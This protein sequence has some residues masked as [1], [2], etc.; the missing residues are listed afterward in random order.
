MIDEF[1]GAHRFLSNFFTLHNP[2]VYNNIDYPSNEHFF[3]AMKTVDQGQ[4]LAMAN[5][6]T[7]GIVKKMG[8]LNGYLNFKIELR[9]NWRGDL[10]FKVMA[11]GLV[12]KFESLYL[13]LRLIETYPHR[14]VEGNWWHDNYW[15][16]CR[17]DKCAGIAKL[18]NLGQMLEIL[19]L[20]LINGTLPAEVD[21]VF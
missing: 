4:R 13:K 2:I 3:Q 21:P 20:H 11:Y 5:A 6:P 10:D 12:K 9:P 15:G 17:C 16:A 7:P 14:L 18:N 19:R 1:K 8:S